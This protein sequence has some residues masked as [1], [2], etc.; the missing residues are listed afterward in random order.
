VIV[1]NKLQ[2]VVATLDDPAAY[3]RV[4]YAFDHKLPIV[5]NGNLRRIGQRWSLEQAR[6]VEI[7]DSADEP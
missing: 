6:L 1:G 3:S 2:S 5:I 7:V 4:V